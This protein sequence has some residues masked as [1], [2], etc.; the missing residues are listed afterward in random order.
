M[1]KIQLKGKKLD[2]YC[3][4]RELS[5]NLDS[6]ASPSKLMEA[7]ELVGDPIGKSYLIVILRELT[8]DGWIKKNSINSRRCNYRIDWR[9]L[10]DEGSRWLRAYYDIKKKDY[11]SKDE[12]WLSHILESIC[13]NYINLKYSSQVPRKMYG[14]TY[15]TTISDVWKEL[16]I[17]H[18]EDMVKNSSYKPKLAKLIVKKEAERKKILSEFIAK[19]TTPIRKVEVTD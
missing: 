1:E 17:P 10:R 11:S 6:E 2:V 3:L 8:E 14:N 12:E 16:L 4:I 7:F 19:R 18:I 5:E 9:F 15:S 13:G